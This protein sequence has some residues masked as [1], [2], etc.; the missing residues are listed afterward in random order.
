ML[1]E[2]DHWQKFQ[3]S[4]VPVL[5]KLCCHLE[6]VKLTLRPPHCQ[7][8]LTRD[9]CKEWIDMWTAHTKGTRHV[10]L[11]HAVM[12]GLVKL[13]YEAAVAEPLHCSPRGLSINC[14]HLAVLERGMHG[15]SSPSLIAIAVLS[16]GK[17]PS[18]LV[19][20]TRDQTWLAAWTLYWQP[21]WPST[22]CHLARRPSIRAC[23]GRDGCY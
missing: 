11:A 20:A 9:Y 22:A 15:V 13:R 23:N 2:G 18:C 19:P 1:V 12:L 14:P 8:C 5:N 7:H 17:F 3:R 16:H 21:G 6:Q 10:T 4:R